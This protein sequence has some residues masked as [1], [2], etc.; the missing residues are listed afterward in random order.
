M[1]PAAA[2]AAQAAAAAEAAAK[3]ESLTIETTQRAPYSA[4]EE[5]IHLLAAIVYYESGWE[6][7]A[8]QLA[9]AN[10]ILNRVLSP[11]FKQNTIKDVIFAPGQFSG[12]IVNGEVSAKFLQFYNMSNEE[13]NKKGCY[14]AALRALAGEN[15]IGDLCFFISVKKANYAKYTKYT[16]INNHCFYTY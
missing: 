16:I 6:P 12:V 13:L 10:V 5:E 3:K 2:A 15:N 9:V 7:A 1:K 8:G 4:T 14:D 11:R